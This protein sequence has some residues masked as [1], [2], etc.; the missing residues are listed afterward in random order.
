ME[1]DR[2]SDEERTKKAKWFIKGSLASLLAAIM[3]G[4]L[5]YGLRR[6]AERNYAAALQRFRASLTLEP[7]KYVNRPGR[8]RRVFKRINEGMSRFN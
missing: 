1:N 2:N 4:G 5:T 8:P 7:V 6:R 3:I